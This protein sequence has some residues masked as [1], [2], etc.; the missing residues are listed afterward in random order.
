MAKGLRL[1]L[2]ITDQYDKPRT[3]EDW[4]PLF[5]ELDDLITKMK[6][7]K[8][9]NQIIDCSFAKTGEWTLTTATK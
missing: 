1:G 9:G 2:N 4:Y 3:D 7:S 8:R 5:R 6:K